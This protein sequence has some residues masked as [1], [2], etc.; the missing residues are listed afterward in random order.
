M[1]SY[2]CYTSNF[3]ESAPEGLVLEACRLKRR[4]FFLKIFPLYI[5]GVRLYLHVYIAITV[6]PPTFS[7]VATWVS[8][9]S[10]QKKSKKN[11]HL[12]G[13]RIGPTELSP[14]LESWPPLSSFSR[15]KYW[16]YRLSVWSWNIRMRTVSW[17]PHLF[18]H[19]KKDS[20]LMP[21]WNT[22][23][24]SPKHETRHLCLQPSGKTMIWVEDIPKG[25]MTP[26][27]FWIHMS[28]AEQ[29]G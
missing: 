8:R 25:E 12:M 2:K 3:K 29:R 6:S 18:L 9:H 20:R 13:C 14:S 19:V 17:Q 10:S 4:S 5:K 27:L 24:Q 21:L 16:L 7:S 26:P 28:I 1:G 11:I 23:F 22:S 15:D